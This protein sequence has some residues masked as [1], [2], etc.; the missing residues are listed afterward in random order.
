MLEKLKSF[1]LT[2]GIA[3]FEEEIRGKI[4]EEAEKYASTRTDNIGN[5]WCEIGG[6]G[7]A[8]ML[9]AHM[10]E[11]G[12]VISKI[13]D[14]GT[15]RFRKVG[16]VDER[17][18]LGRGVKVHTRGGIV[19]GV[20]GILPPHLMEDR[21]EEISKMPDIKELRVD[22]GCR[23]KE[24]AVTRGV[25]LMDPVTVSKEVLML[26]EDIISS[27]SLD[28][29]FGCVVLLEL[30]HSLHSRISNCTI[31][32]VW[33]TQE[34]MGLRGAKVASG[35]DIDMV[36]VIDSCS[37]TDFPQAPDHT[38]D[39]VLGDGPVARFLDEGAMANPALIK[40]VQRIAG[41]YNIPLQIGITGGRTDG[42]V[43]Q[44]R[45]ARMV[46]LGVGVRYTHSPV[47]CIHLGDL[48]NLVSLTEAALME[49]EEHGLE[50]LK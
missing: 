19:P 21:E 35:E 33:S 43:I 20:I 36:I 8:I 13:E 3:G 7:P 18:L 49:I 14:E 11:I 46:P 16:G 25:A 2:P 32:F 30:L 24:E 40:F 12:M 17:C 34:E 4:K 29:R 42:A 44:E 27:R 5:L 22:I 48:R 10:D 38:S 37:S 45:G 6:G 28:D 9:I 23:S 1:L 39:I 47:E 26:G 50:V 31:K 15:L 41:E